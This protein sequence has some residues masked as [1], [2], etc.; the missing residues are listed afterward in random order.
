M[1]TKER[2]NPSLSEICDTFDLAV[3]VADESSDSDSADFV[4]LLLG[5]IGVKNGSNKPLLRF[6]SQIKKEKDKIFKSKWHSPPGI[7]R[8]VFHV[9]EKDYE[10]ILKV[11]PMDKELV[12]IL[13]KAGSST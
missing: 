6:P 12:K 9:P 4:L 1:F 8:K 2:I 13:A 7:F 3:K 10:D 11:P 5:N